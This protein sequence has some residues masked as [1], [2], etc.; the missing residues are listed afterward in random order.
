[1]D[2]SRIG[3]R[4]R[5]TEVEADGGVVTPDNSHPLGPSVYGLGCKKW[6]DL[7]QHALENSKGLDG[8][9]SSYIA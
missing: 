6:L 1:M 3:W 9:A 4:V 2:G 8:C 5:S 7:A